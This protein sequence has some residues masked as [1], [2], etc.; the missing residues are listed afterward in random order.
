[1]T[2]SEISALLL[3]HLSSDQALTFIEKAKTSGM[4]TKDESA[5][6]VSIIGLANPAINDD[7]AEHLPQRPLLMFGSMVEAW[8]NSQSEGA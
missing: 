3:D 4:I 5:E 6:L 8:R 1:M 2:V 7:G